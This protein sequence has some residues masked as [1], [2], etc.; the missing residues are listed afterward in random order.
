MEDIMKRNYG[1]LFYWFIPAILALVHHLIFGCLSVSRLMDCALIALVVISMRPIFFNIVKD[2]E[3]SDDKNEYV[4]VYNMFFFVAVY[5]ALTIIGI[6]TSI[7]QAFSIAYIVI[8]SLYIILG[9][10]FS[11]SQCLKPEEQRIG[12]CGFIQIIFVVSLPIWIPNIIV[13]GFKIGMLLFFLI[14]VLS[15]VGVLIGRLFKKV[16]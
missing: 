14:T 12:E 9:S 4:S 15:G 3:N 11:I 2:T 10:I 7:L 13:N 1:N 16:Y 5:A 6:A 8:I